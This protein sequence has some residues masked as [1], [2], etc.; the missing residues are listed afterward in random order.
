MEQGEKPTKAEVGR[1]RRAT[2][3]ARIIAA[4]FKHFGSEDGLDTRIEDIARSAGVT[5]MTFYNHFSGMGELREAV[6]F[7]LT[8]EFLDDVAKAISTLEDPRERAAA[9]VRFYLGRVAHDP[10]W[11]RS[12]LTLGASGVMFGAET[13]REAEQTV[14]QGISEGA[15]AIDDSGLGRDLVLGTSLAAIASILSGSAGPDY[16]AKVAVAILH[17]L[18]V[19]SPEAE[20]IASRPLPPLQ[21]GRS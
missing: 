5:R 16:P 19:A 18:G 4:A 13:Y 10:A 7:E 1:Q 15:L 14:R 20:R 6:G 21:T 8:H 12:M 3:R 17:G 2:T 9:A 11:G